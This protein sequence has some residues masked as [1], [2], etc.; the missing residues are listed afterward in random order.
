MA[1][2]EPE[3]PVAKV[4]TKTRL[5][6]GLGDFGFVML[7]QGCALFLLYFYTEIVGLP[8]LLAGGIYMAGM[9]WDAISDPFIA[10]WTER[11]ARKIGRYGGLVGAAALPLALAYPLLFTQPFDGLLPA[12]LWAL[13][14]HV[15]FRTAYTFASM[16]YNTMPARL[17]RNPG[18][19]NTLAA[20][21]VIGA[22][23]GGLMA[24]LATPVM[25][26]VL[27][28]QMEEGPAYL[29]AALTLGALAGFS[30]WSCSGLMA[31]PA[32]EPAGDDNSQGTTGFHADLLLA[33]RRAVS[34]PRFSRLMIIMALATLSFGLYTQ[35]VLY[36]VSYHFQR[37]D[38][39]PLALGLPALIMIPL[40]PAWAALAHRLSKPATLAAGLLLAA[41]G[42]AGLGLVPRDAIPM[43]LGFIALAAAGNACLPV[44]FWSLLPDAIDAHSDRT[45]TRIEARMFGLATFVQKTVSGLTGLLIGLAL[46]L[47]GHEAGGS[48]SV[49][50]PVRHTIRLLCSAGPALCLLA[51]IGVTYRYGRIRD[52]V[53]SQ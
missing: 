12:A 11:K 30:L 48:E 34:D 47:A 7:W 31:E 35:T 4:N 20:L 45:G 16:P 10:T 49:S 29:I 23:A 19:R 15:G 27:N 2:H 36:L 42:Y 8:A 17:T 50:E 18:T 37:P 13:A 43:A 51:L 6:F 28:L 32:Q 1:S 41:L 44:M 52:T 53:A 5:G 3:K 33:L 22:A 46:Y 9:I 14:T 40:A 26:D 39:T 24:A 21:R 25:I 38:L